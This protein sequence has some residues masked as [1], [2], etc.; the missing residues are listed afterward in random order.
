[1]KSGLRRLVNR[2]T[3]PVPL[4]PPRRGGTMM[5]LRGGKANME[6]YLRTYNRSGTVHSIVSLLQEA[7]ASPT[8]HLYRKQPQDGRVRYTT[9]DKGS[10]QRVEVVQHAAIS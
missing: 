2:Q 8:W 1:M 3:P 5:S 6:A 4:A 9:G 10:D 7:A